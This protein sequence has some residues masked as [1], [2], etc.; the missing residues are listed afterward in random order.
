MIRVT[1]FYN[2]LLEWFVSEESIR[3]VPT[4]GK[5]LSFDSW[6]VPK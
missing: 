1:T 3:I 5:I 2:D 4:C 6:I